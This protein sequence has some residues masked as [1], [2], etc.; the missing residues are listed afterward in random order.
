[1]S[2]DLIYRVIFVEDTYGREFHRVII[3]KLVEHRVIEFS[4][5]PSIQRMPAKKCNHS[6]TRKVKARL[7]SISL[8]RCLFVID[9]EGRRKSIAERDVLDHFRDVKNNIRVVVIS[10]RHEK[11]LCLGLGGNVSSCKNSPEDTIV[12]LLQRRGLRVKAYEKDFLRRY[13]RYINIDHLINDPDFKEYIRA[14]R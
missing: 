6:L 5:R 7:F 9:S 10:P 12:R 4:T 8:W 13:A 1:M 2:R 11:L 14:L 3:D